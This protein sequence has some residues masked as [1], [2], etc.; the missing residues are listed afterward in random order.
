MWFLG[1]GTH[2]SLL[3]AF[4]DYLA[5]VEAPQNEARSLAVIAEAERGWCP[6]SRFKYRDQHPPPLRS[7]RLGLRTYLSQGTTDRDA[8]VEQAAP[9]S[10][11]CST[12]RRATLQPDR[13][14]MYSPMYIDQ[15]GGQPPIETVGRRARA[16]AAPLTW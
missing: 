3:V 5:V 9:T 14:A 1:G 6:A 11:S 2:N 4:K 13:M 10:T 7:R 15:Q 12:R 16:R 8:R